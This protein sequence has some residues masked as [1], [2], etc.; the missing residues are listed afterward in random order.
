MLMQHIRFQMNASPNYV[1]EE[2][3]RLVAAGF[4]TDDHAQLIDAE[5]VAA[6]FAGDLGRKLCEGRVLREFKFS[7]LD[8]AAEY[9]DGVTN[10]QVL[11]QGV[12]DCAL[13]EDDGITVVDFKTDHISGGNVSYAVERYRQQVQTYA[14]ALSRI[15]ELPIKA[16]ALHF[17]AVDETVYL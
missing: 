6:F 4:L 2:V 17:F 12:V 13:M 3:E 5:K 11:L 8:D 9:A 15:F 1:K 16:K 7:I 10:E 14:N